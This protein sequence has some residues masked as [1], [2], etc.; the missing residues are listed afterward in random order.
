[1]EAL[2]LALLELRLRSLT[3][4]LTRPISTR[5]MREKEARKYEESIS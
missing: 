2:A 1:M 5:Y 3:Q 4:V